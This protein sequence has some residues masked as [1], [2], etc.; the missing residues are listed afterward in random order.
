MPI[1]RWTSEALS[2]S[3]LNDDARRCGK[4]GQKSTGANSGPDVDKLYGTEEVVE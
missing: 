3:I 1:A 2:G 4:A